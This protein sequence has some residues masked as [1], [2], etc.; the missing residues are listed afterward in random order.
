MLSSLNGTR[1]F[2]VTAR[3]A[4]QV[5]LSV[6]DAAPGLDGAALSADAG[7]TAVSGAI[8]TSGTNELLVAM[9]LQIGAMAASPS[10]GFTALTGVSS[11]YLGTTAYLSEAYQGVAAPGTYQAAW[12][13][14][15]SSSWFTLIAALRPT[16]AATSGE[17]GTAVPVNPAAFRKLQL[18]VPGEVA[19]PGTASG[20]ISVLATLSA[21]TPF[22]VTINGVDNFWNVVNA[23]DTVRIT[24]TDA[25]AT[26]P[27]NGAL[28]AGSRT[29]QVTFNTRGDLHPHRGRRQRRH[30]DAEREPPDAGDGVVGESRVRSILRPS[31]AVR[32]SGS[33]A[34]RPARPAQ[35][36]P[37]ATRSA[38]WSTACTP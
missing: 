20:K 36:R 17:T 6:S 27:A 33:A 13:L 22:S 38:T 8:A 7:L 5:S 37:G 2:S 14:S 18:L 11:L 15:G 34:R 29:A 4:G 24:S 35:G 10:G 3:K 19:A 23:S 25:T 12:S 30:Q 26:L 31:A 21:G 16:L 28:A 32:R 9:D 1:M